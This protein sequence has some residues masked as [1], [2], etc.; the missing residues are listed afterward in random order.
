MF[1]KYF[2]TTQTKRVYTSVARFIITTHIHSYLSLIRTFV[3]NKHGDKFIPCRLFDTRNLGSLVLGGN[4]QMVKSKYFVF[5]LS[6][7]TY[8]QRSSIDK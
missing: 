5:R 3:H 6:L 2:T 7:S 1:R 8:F 4:R